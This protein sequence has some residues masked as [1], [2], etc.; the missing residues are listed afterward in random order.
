M[1]AFA[2]P[3]KGLYLIP[4]LLTVEPHEVRA[5]VSGKDSGAARVEEVPDTDKTRDAQR[6][7][8]AA[9]TRAISERHPRVR[10]AAD[11]IPAAGGAGDTDVQEGGAVFRREVPGP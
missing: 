1:K 4:D 8:G 6:Q 9:S 3:E 2:Q 7:I 5:R 11:L 10:T